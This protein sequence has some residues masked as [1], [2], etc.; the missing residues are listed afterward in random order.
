M[1]WGRLALVS[2]AIGAAAGAVHVLALPNTGRCPVHDM[3][4]QALCNAKACFRAQVVSVSESPE[5]RPH[6]LKARLARQGPH[7][8]FEFPRLPGEPERVVLESPD[9]VYIFWPTAEQGWKLT[10]QKHPNREGAGAQLCGSN[11][12][13]RLEPGQ[14]PQRTVTV[15]RK[16]DNRLARRFWVDQQHGVVTKVECYGDGET[17]R[18]SWALEEVEYAANLPKD[19]FEP[20]EFVRVPQQVDHPQPVSLT[21]AT[22]RAGFNPELP[23]WVPSGYELVEIWQESVGGRPSIRLVYSDGMETFSL[24]QSR[25][26]QG[27]PM[28]LRGSQPLDA[29]VEMVRRGELALLNWADDRLEYTLLGSQ[30]NRELYQMAERMVAGQTSRPSPAANG[31]L[32]VISRG[33][34]RLEHMVSAP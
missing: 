33:W 19:L 32:P 14:G 18:A 34:V 5:G 30:S 27:H 1:R 29:G 8:R 12:E 15:Y 7:A 16:R 20:P 25:L 6:L 31:V 3:L 22:Q 9:T 17:M 26:S 23:A 13:W 10:R 28:V 21:E 4:L 11:Y 2:L 24:L